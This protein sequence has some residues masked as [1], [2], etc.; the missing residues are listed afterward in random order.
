MNPLDLGGGAFLALYLGLLAVAVAAGMVIPHAARPAGRRCREL[1]DPAALAVLAG[2]AARLAETVVARLLAAGALLIAGK[3]FVVGGAAAGVTGKAERRVLALSQPM[4]WAAIAATLRPEV[5]PVEQRLETAGLLFDGDA[6]AAMRW[7]Q[8]VPYLALLALGVM[9]LAVG[10]WRERPVGFLVLLLGVTAVLAVVR[11]AVLDRRTTAGV[12][13]LTA[14]RRRAE[15]LR[16]APTRD[17]LDLAVALFGTVV[18]LGSGWAGFHRL[19]S[20]PADGGGDGGGS[21][22]GSDGG[23]GGG[24]CGGCS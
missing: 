10:V 22:G 23:C 7:R 21:D 6:A 1:R 16:R 20:R 13:M 12:A 19:R 15:R 3:R 4:P 17:E 14:A 2:G 11:W 24:G 9:K 18:L 8:T 5:A